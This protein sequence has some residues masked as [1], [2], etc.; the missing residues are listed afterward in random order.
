MSPRREWKAD[1][2]RLIPPH[3][4]H[5]KQPKP[6]VLHITVFSIKHSFCT[7]IFTSTMG[8]ENKRVAIVGGLGGMSF[9]NAALYAGL[10][11]VQ[12]YE[13]VPL[14]AESALASASPRTP[15]ASWMPSG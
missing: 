11:N 5:I 13:Q 7:S 1:D 2:Y 10:K 9:L 6:A 14:F 3:F 4:I 8:F 15:I 12:L